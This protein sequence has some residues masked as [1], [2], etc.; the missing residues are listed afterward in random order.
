[1]TSQPEPAAAAKDLL[2]EAAEHIAAFNRCTLDTPADHLPN[3]GDIYDATGGLVQLLTRL[4][5]ALGQLAGRLTALH[6]IRTLAVVQSRPDAN[7]ASV[8]ADYDQQ[9]TAAVE[10][11]EKAALHANSA[12][13]VSG[14]L[15]HTDPPDAA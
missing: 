8:V 3:P 9:L 7:P 2:T 5:Q 10:H 11:L 1:M 4:P 14:I 13:S 12:W 15:I 6:D